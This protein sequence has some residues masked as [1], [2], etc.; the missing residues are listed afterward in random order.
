MAQLQTLNAWAY[1]IDRLGR[2]EGLLPKDRRKLVANNI[3]TRVPTSL[4]SQLI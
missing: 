2:R 3:H 1:A 4:C